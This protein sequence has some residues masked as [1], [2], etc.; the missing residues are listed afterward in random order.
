MGSEWGQRSAFHGGFCLRFQVAGPSCPKLGIY[1]AERKPRV[2][3]SPTSLHLSGS[4]PLSS[5]PLCIREDMDSAVFETFLPLEIVQNNMGAKVMSTRG[6]LKRGKTDYQCHPQT[7]PEQPCWESVKGSRR[8]DPWSLTHSLVRDLSAVP[9]LAAGEGRE[10][11]L[12]WSWDRRRAAAQGPETASKDSLDARCPPNAHS[13]EHRPF[14][15]F[16]RPSQQPAW[17]AVQS[18]RSMTQILRRTSF[19]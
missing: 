5:L 15:H 12:G 11:V 18:G 19:Y 16:Q 4:S 2:L 8:S 9:G 17:E 3:A 7:S 10:L 1:Q 6:K 14:W 13:S